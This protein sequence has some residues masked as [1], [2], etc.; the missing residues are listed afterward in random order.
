MAR[1]G[2]LTDDARGMFATDIIYSDLD[3]SQM[4]SLPIGQP[5]RIVDVG[6]VNADKEGETKLHLTAL[7]LSAHDDRICENV[8]CFAKHYLRHCVR[9]AG[10][11]WRAEPSLPAN[12]SFDRPQPPAWTCWDDR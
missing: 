6:L 3:I 9:A 4:E 10:R 5:H 12:P 1:L 11:R 7:A 2:V 8:H